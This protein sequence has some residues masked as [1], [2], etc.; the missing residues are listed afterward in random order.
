MS[1]GPVPGPGPLL[2]VEA[3]LAT[4]L[5]GVDPLEPEPVTLEHAQ[6][7]VTAGAIRGGA[8]VPAFDNS[9][10]D[11]FAV[12]SG[13][14]RGATAAEPVELSVKGESRAGTPWTP[15]LIHI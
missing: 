4:V 1:T 7:R 9:A 12:R 3:A 10:M 5:E 15:A 11:G 8:D 6:G 2:P 13:D 14:V